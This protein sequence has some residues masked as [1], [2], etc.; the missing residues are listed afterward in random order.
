MKL[1]TE[2]SLRRNRHIN[3]LSVIGG[4]GPGYNYTWLDRILIEN[5]IKVETLRGDCRLH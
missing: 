4:Q 1:L 2:I 5:L 3:I